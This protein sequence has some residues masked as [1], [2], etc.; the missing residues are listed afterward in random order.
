MQL[1]FASGNKHK[2]LELQSKLNE[3]INIISMR[4]AGFEGDIEEPGE[5][6][7]E[8]AKIKAEFIHNLFQEN[9]FADD[10]GLEIE[11]L[12]GE[13]GV[14]SARYAGEGCTFADNNEKVLKKLDGIENRSARFKTVIHLIFNEQHYLFVGE[15]LGKITKTNRGLEGFGY[16]PIFIPDGYTQTFAEMTLE[17]KNQ[18]S[19]RAKAVQKLSEFLLNR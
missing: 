16:D 6:L 5:T 13:P 2:L 12:N 7:E 8:N 1:I 4:E 15:V 14:Y 19:H 18:I 11:A 3:S 9:C 17:E 10:S